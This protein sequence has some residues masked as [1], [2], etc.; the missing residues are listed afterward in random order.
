MRRIVLLLA[1]F[2]FGGAVEVRGLDMRPGD[3]EVRGTAPLE[4]AERAVVVTG[5][6]Y[7]AQRGGLYITAVGIRRASELERLAPVALTWRDPPD[8]QLVPL[9]QLYGPVAPTPSQEAR[10]ERRQ[11][12]DS[13]TVAAIAAYQALGYSVPLVRGQPRLP[14][15]TTF[16]RDPLAGGGSAGFM[17]AL[18][19]V[20]RFGD[21]T[22]G[23]KI[24]G[25]GAI[26]PGGDIGSVGGVRFKVVGARR[27]G[28]QFF[29]VPARR[30]PYHIWY[31]TYASNYEEARQCRCAGA[32]RLVPVRTLADALAFLRTLR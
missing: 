18:A 3:A 22:H 6:P 1:V 10:I 20:D 28:A 21:L 12:L 13:Q 17:L 14:Y 23:Y 24:A 7:R 15:R 29:L 16:R 25:T 5:H 2:M 27:A 26:A 4:D 19:I 32:M 30:G 8:G 11:M 9:R 31:G